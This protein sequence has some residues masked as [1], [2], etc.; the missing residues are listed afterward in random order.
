MPS[1]LFGSALSARRMERGRFTCPE[2]GRDRPYQRTV[3]KRSLAVLGQPLLSMG[4]SGEYIECEVCLST[5]R[6]EVLAFDAG[7]A[8]SR[9]QVEYQRAMRRV[10]ALL[11][12]ADGVLR[13]P[14]IATVQWVYE[15]VSGKRLS[16]EE[17]IAEVDEVGRYPTTVARY[18]ARVVGYLNDYG[19]EQVLRA[20]ASISSSDGDVHEREARMLRRLGGVM[21]MEPGRVEAVI[22]EAAGR[23]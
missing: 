18:L 23:R 13:E 21:A 6:P 5:F 11:A 16:R 10:L 17:V 4:T 3:V 15:A 2:C 20:A 14:E 8:S 22:G 9:V 7:S 19:K 1:I 12:A